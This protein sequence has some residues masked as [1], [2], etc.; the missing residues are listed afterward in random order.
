MSRA[1][2]PAV[3]VCIPVFNG[4]P[5]IGAAIESLLRQSFSDFE[6]IVVDNASTDGT[7]A[8]V[9]SFRDP[10]L[11]L[12]RNATNI[13]AEGNWNLAVRECRGEWVKLLCADDLLYP[14]C[15]VTQVAAVS[16][17]DAASVAMVSARRDVIDARGEVLI[18]GRGARW[19]GGDRGRLDFARAALRMGS[20][21]IGEPAAVLFRRSAWISAKG[22]DASLPYLIDVDCWYRLLGHGTLRPLPATLCAFRVSSGSWSARLQRNQAAQTRAFLGRLAADHPGLLGPVALRMALWRASTTALLR[23]VVFSHPRLIA[24]IAGRRSPSTART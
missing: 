3:S 11:R 15:L 13:G 18:R 21:P 5:F 7:V 14:D 1:A 4:A 17:V 8:V 12:I 10:R 23:Q 2:A 6:L 19:P 22:F 16:G 20:N 24:W 9:E